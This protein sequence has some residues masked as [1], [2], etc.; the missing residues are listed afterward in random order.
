MSE[1]QKAYGDFIA[2]GNAINVDIGFVPDKFQAVAKY[3]ETNPVTYEWRKSRGD[4]ANDNGQFGIT[5]PANGG[6]VTKNAS[7]AA[8]FASYDTVELKALLPAPNGTGEASAS[9]GTF[10][11]GDTQPTARTSSVLGTVVRPSTANGFLY[12]CTVSTGVLGTE[13]TFPTTPGDT[14]TDD[15]SNTWI[16]RTEKLK[17]IGAK[18]IT[19]GAD[20][21]TDT[22]EWSW[23]AESNGPVASERDSA[24][25]DPVGKYPND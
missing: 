14:V 24:T 4:T 10:L 19:V 5:R 25:F 13:P 21:S 2:D 20:L 17:N 3:E 6:A 16:T 11:A 8:G 9:I 15:Q 22:D 1:F 23:E 7:A 18:G 12:E